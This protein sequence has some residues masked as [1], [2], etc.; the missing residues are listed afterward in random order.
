MQKA[1]KVE[2]ETGKTILNRL[3]YTNVMLAHWQSDDEDA[4]AK[5]LAVL[6]VMN[7]RVAEGDVHCAPDSV[8]Y[9]VVIQTWARS[10]APDKAVK[11]WAF[12]VEILQ[13]Y[14]DGRLPHVRPNE[15]MFTAVLNACA[16]TTGERSDQTEA[17]QV[18][19]QVMEEFKRHNYGKPNS[20]M[21][22]TLIEVFTRNV[23][24]MEVRLKYVRA[25][26]QRCC[27]DGMVN[28][29]IIKIIRRYVPDLF[30]ELPRNVHKEMVVPPEWRMNADREKF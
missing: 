13:E 29:A 4:V 27:D 1:R 15:K 14:K 16:Y 17:V 21:Y 2:L 7:D 26:F 3:M 25:A 5:V 28:E 24:D 12:L 8:T 30:Q 20:L 6:N 9:S 19:L 11:A 10:N 23:V 22:S 18:A